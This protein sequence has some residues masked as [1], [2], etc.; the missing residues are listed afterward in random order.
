[1]LN[2][3]N[4]IIARALR[5]LGCFVLMSAGFLTPAY[6]Q[7]T[8][9]ISVGGVSLAIPSPNGFS[10][11]TQQ[12]TVLY[13]LQ[14]QF[15]APASELFAT[16]IPQQHVREVL[17]GNIPELPRRFTVQTATSSIAVSISTSYFAELKSI[18]K[19]QIDEIVKQIAKQLPNLTKKVNEGIANKYDVDLALSISQMVPMPVHEE[20]D[21]TIA[22]SMLVKYD[23]NDADGKPAPFIGAVTSTLVHVK[24]KVLFLYSYAE[25]SGV[26]W[27][28]EAAKQW[29]NAVVAA[30]P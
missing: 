3:S 30:N 7:T 27:S 1:M 29:A 18:M 24:G 22:Y 25:E 16:F 20:T 19:S 11:V 6:A 28:R 26:E 9:D 8:T 14:K 23:M 21:R 5:M 17:K 2:L 4:L 10:P 13:D 15:V 12:M